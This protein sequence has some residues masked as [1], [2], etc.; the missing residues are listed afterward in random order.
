LPAKPARQRDVREPADR[1]RELRSFLSGPGSSDHYASPVGG[2]IPVDSQAQEFQPAAVLAAG[3]VDPDFSDSQRPVDLSVVFAAR[4]LP[5][6]AR[7]TVGD[8]LLFPLLLPV[9][10]ELADPLVKGHEMRVEVE[11]HRMPLG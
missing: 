11:V 7:R 1:G 9:A 5:A 3:R 2:T 6:R 4:P 8:D 10:A